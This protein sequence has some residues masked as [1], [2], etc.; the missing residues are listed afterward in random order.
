MMETAARLA[1]ASRRSK[2]EVQQCCFDGYGLKQVGLKGSAPEFSP[3][4]LLEESGTDAEVSKM[5]DEEEE[6]DEYSEYSD[7]YS[8]EGSDEEHVDVPSTGANKGVLNDEDE[9]SDESG[10]EG[11]EGE[12]SE[13]EHSHEQSE[14]E[15]FGISADDEASAAKK[16]AEHND[17]IASGAEA[18]EASGCE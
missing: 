11:L 5:N 8:S 17:M 2:V 16:E 3:T 9:Y 12:Q 14:G 1:L 10:S 6:E 7:E 4:G 18:D 13:E 15:Y